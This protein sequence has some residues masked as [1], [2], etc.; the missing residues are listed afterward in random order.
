[1]YKITKNAQ[2][3]LEAVADELAVSDARYEDAEAS[4]N[5]FGAW[6]ERPQSSVKRYDPC[7]YVQGS[8]RLGTA[9]R[10]SDETGEYDIDAVCELRD[11]DKAA[12][13][14][15]ELKELLGTEV[16]SYHASQN[17]KRPIKEGQRCWTLRYSRGA[18][19]HM[20]ILP[21]LPNHEEQR[22]LLAEHNHDQNWADTAIVI[23]D[24]ERPNYHQISPDWHRSNP[25]GYS[26]WFKSKMTVIFEERRRILAEKAQASV[27]D[28]P[29]YRI[30]TPLQSAI[31]IL[32]HHRDNMFAANPGDKPISIVITT[33]AAH[34]Y[35]GER[36][37]AEALLSILTNM[38]EHMRRDEHGRW[39]ICNPVDPSENFA[40]KWEKHPEREKAFFDWLEQARNDFGHAAQLSETKQISAT[41]QKRLGSVAEE[42][43][44]R[45]SEPSSSTLRSTTVAPIAA[46][47]PKPSFGNEPRVPTKPKGFA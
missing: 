10:P 23:T 36:T 24:N 16:K 28:I 30:R 8:F 14:Q 9:I 25:K 21:S 47:A 44:T 37:I 11:L 31:M 18:Q 35:G 17:M 42:A 19:F 6:L 4:Y 40:D 7:V 39:L 26:D 45:I 22:V 2:D 13:S 12:L 34:S 38:D 29:D 43:A 46:N 27:E 20:D 33:L 3:Y 5:S 41:F 15:A 1:M 32:K